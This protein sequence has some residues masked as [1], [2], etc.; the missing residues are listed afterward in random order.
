MRMLHSPRAKNEE[1]LHVLLNDA[2]LAALRVARGRGDGKGRIFR[3][4]RTG[5]P[6]EHPRHLFEPALREAAIEGFHLAR[7]AA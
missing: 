4:E 1:P 2:A 3:C 5:E 6:L 7:S